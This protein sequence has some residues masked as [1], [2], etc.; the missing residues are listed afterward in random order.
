MTARERIQKEIERWF[1]LEPLFFSVY[2]THQ[3]TINANMKC[4]LRTGRGRIEYNPEQINTLNERRLSN[5]LSV[6]MIRILLGHPYS[7]RPLGCNP[8]VLRMASDMVIAPAYPTMSGDM[9]HPSKV[10]LPEGKNYEW[11]IS[12]LNEKFHHKDGN[13]PSEGDTSGNPDKNSE[14]ELQGGSQPNKN[15]KGNNQ[16]RGQ[17]QNQL[18]DGDSSKNNGSNA[19]D[20]SRDGQQGKNQNKLNQ[21][22]QN[23]GQH[24]QSHNQGKNGMGGMGQSQQCY[25]Q[26]SQQS[27][28]QGG[29]Q[30]DELEGQQ[31]DEQE[32]QNQQESSN[33]E[34]D[35]ELSRIKNKIRDSRKSST[36]RDDGDADYTALWEEDQFVGQ[37]IKELIQ[38][39]TQWGSVPGGL[40]EIIKKAAEGKIDYRN[41]L[42]M[43]R[44]SILSQQRHLTRMRPSRR[45]GFEQ[46]GS[47]YEFTTKLL[48]AIDTSGSVGSEELGRYLR[49]ITSFFKY[50]IQEISM[51]MFDYVVHGEPIVFKS[52]EKNKHELKV[53]G[54]GGTCFQAP[55]DYVGQ[56]QEYDGLIII[57]D[58]CAP[59]PKLPPHFRTK[60]LW[61][62]DNEGKYRHCDD[63]RKT[64][65]VCLLQN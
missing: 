16:N 29:Q 38:S 8:K 46:M 39:T 62:I 6:E 24:G 20:N 1:L 25:E 15:P 7:R 54:R 65:R 13:H 53:K 23:Q 42:R 12:R 48:I 45:F 51:L 43:F 34:D 47:R 52:K 2:C 56:H 58:G 37:Q 26:E 64:G 30:G 5:M 27:D 60:V 21:G 35:G 28:G 44:S 32:S 49:V 11:Y 14:T 17:E 31:G 61:V 9:A 10:G 55:I 63:L 36:S 19:S 57:T 33:R 22:Q 59:T 3:L 40:M 50:G 41:M 18:N 4:P